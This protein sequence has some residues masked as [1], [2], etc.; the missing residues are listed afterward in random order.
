MS[1]QSEIIEEIK[2]ACVPIFTKVTSRQVSEKDIAD[3]ELPA[4]VITNVETNFDKQ[5]RFEV[6]ENYTIKM[7]ILIEDRPADILFDPLQE[8]GDKQ[9]EAIRALFGSSDLLALINKD[10]I[11]LKNSNASNAVNQYSVG[12]AIGCI[13]TIM[14]TAVVSYNP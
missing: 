8:L 14:C 1:R 4:L 13:L 5:Q 11:I 9:E 10:G 12:S 2:K 6:V 7:L 3:T